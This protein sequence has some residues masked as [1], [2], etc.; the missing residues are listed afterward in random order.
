MSAHEGVGPLGEEV[1]AVDGQ[2][3]GLGEGV[4]AG[5]LVGG[6]ELVKLGVDGQVVGFAPA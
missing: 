4:G 6:L 5:G 1:E 3:L 2:Q